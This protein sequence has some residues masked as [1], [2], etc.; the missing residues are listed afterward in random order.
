MGLD[1]MRESK[2]LH[3]SIVV[4][5]RPEIIKMAPIV[6][7]CKDLDLAHE[8]IHTG[9]HYSYEL[10]SLITGELNLAVPD[11]NLHIGSGSHAEETAKALVGLEN[12]FRE[13][14]PKVVLVQGDTNSTLAA[15]LAASKLHIHVGHM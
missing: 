6:K 12:I 3:V 9:Q 14:Q 11:H 2:N 7:V 15:A 13:T 1:H 5:T 4:G 10:D 8:I